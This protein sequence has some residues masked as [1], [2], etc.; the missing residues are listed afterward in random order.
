LDATKVLF[1]HMLTDKA[2]AINNIGGLIST[3]LGK[4]EK[5]SIK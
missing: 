3:I 5:F 1:I 4:Q 2:M